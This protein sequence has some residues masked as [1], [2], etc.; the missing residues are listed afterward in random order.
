MIEGIV[1]LPGNGKTLLAVRRILSAL[2]ARRRVLAN[3]HSNPAGNWEFA[4]WED[5]KEASDA[6]CV[7]DEAH[8]WF[9]ARNWSKTVQTD[10]SIFQ[11]HR[12][13]GLDMIWVA[14]HE[15]R[16]DVGIRELTA[17][18]WDCR[19]IGQFVVANKRSIDDK[20]TVFGREIFLSSSKLWNA[21]N[22]YE[23]IGDRE[24][25]GAHDGRAGADRVSGGPVVGSNYVR[26]DIGGSVTYVKRT[27]PRLEHLATVDLHARLGYDPPKLTSNFETSL[28]RPL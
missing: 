8:M 28:T 14:Q 9:S 24:G 20:K 17:W 26:V 10:L 6:L 1:G 3:F 25:N 2:E 7:I 15:N 12:K 11:Q 23:V 27:D 5:M 21:Y 18:I 4:L 16:V 13:N 22:T 19:L